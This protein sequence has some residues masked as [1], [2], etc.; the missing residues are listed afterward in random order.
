MHRY[1]LPVMSGDGTSA[2][3]PCEQSGSRPQEAVACG[4]KAARN[5][6]SPTEQVSGQISSFK[7]CSAHT[8]ASMRFWL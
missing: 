6:Q 2:L 7:F 1:S 5:A 3:C 8:E 4:V